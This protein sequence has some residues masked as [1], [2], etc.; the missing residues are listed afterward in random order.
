[1]LLFAF[2]STILLLK[3]A[4]TYNTDTQRFSNIPT[5]IK[6]FYFASIAAILCTHTLHQSTIIYGE[7]GVLESITALLAFAGGFIFLYLKKYYPGQ[8]QR[9]F[10]LAFAI[11]MLLFAF[12]EISWGQRIFGWETPAYLMEN[13]IQQE[14]NLHNLFNEYFDFAY[15]VFSSVAASIFFYRKQLI[16]LLERIPKIKS[17]AIFVPSSYF[18]YS[19]YIFIYL[20]FYTF[21]IE[22]GAETLEITIA[23]FLFFYAYNLLI[24]IKEPEVVREKDSNT[25]TIPNTSI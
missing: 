2:A 17:L 6:S 22:K 15:L 23:I 19:G 24:R 13:N 1:L 21:L 12:E 16:A 11:A 20:M 3:G 25:V 18:F 10:L 5:R 14:S 4:W 7:D 9:F 8:M